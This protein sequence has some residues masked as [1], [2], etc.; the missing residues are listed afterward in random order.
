MAA[1][2]Q[3]RGYAVLCEAGCDVLARRVVNGL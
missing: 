3:L 1:F 2:W